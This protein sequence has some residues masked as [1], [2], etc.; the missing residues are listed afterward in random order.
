[1]SLYGFSNS[2]FNNT[3]SGVL[4]ISDGLGT[5]I[6]NGQITSNNINSNTINNTGNINI[7]GDIHGGSDNISQFNDTITIVNSSSFFDVSQCS[8]INTVSSIIIS[9][10]ELS[11]LDNVSS[12][13]QNQFSQI[14]LRL[15]S[16]ESNISNLLTSGQNNINNTNSII[17]SII[18]LNT[19]VTIDETNI[20]NN[21]NSIV[22]LN[23]RITTDET[24]ITNTNSNIN[25]L[26]T[27]ITTDETNINATITSINS[28]NTRITTDESNSI[29]N[30]SNISSLN[31]RITTDEKRL[32]VDTSYL[33]YIF[34]SGTQLS[35][36][37]IYY[38]PLVNVLY[39]SCIKSESI[40]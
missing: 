36:N 18:S 15:S 21:T 16:D 2:G 6:N 33:S 12:N 1:M 37:G 24:N 40:K 32:T 4:N 25:S 26:N 30:T 39:S 34:Q 27:R 19:R 31:S 3:L 38:C 7:D 17:S 8:G 35:L 28:L 10:T 23:T 11:F 14:D 5:E 9:P 29:S 22:S 13:V 20:N